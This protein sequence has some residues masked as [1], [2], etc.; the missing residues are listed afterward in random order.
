MLGELSWQPEANR[1][2]DFSAGDG[3]LL[4]VLSKTGGL[5]SNLLKNVI[6]KR[7]HYT[8]GLGGNASLGVDLLED[9]VDVDRVALLADTLSLLLV[10]RSDLGLGGGLLLALLASDFSWHLLFECV[11]A[12][13]QTVTGVDTPALSPFIPFCR[14][15]CPR[16]TFPGS[17]DPPTNQH[18]S[19]VTSRERI[20]WAIDPSRFFGG[21]II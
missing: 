14:I 7:V 17:L 10:G 2:L 1:S 6:D 18:Y 5:G 20:G 4:V 21:K 11:F 15:T 12:R 13:L 9:L 16:I 19:R 8:H 3:R